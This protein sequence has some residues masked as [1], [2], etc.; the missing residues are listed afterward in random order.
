[1]CQLSMCLVHRHTVF[2]Q[3]VCVCIRSACVCH[4]M[5]LV[6]AHARDTR[7]TYNSSL[8][9]PSRCYF[10]F[11]GDRRG[12]MASMKTTC[13]WTHMCRHSSW[14]FYLIVSSFPL[15]CWNLLWRFLICSSETEETTTTTTTTTWRYVNDTPVINPHPSVGLTHSFSYFKHAWPHTNQIIIFENI[16]SLPLLCC[17]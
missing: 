11:S 2:A 4:H 16:Q 12:W 8:Q 13:S 9:P 3:C 17:F 7:Y 1:M 10:I 6:C 5:S 15:S 14:T